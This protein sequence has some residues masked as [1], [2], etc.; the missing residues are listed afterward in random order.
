MWIFNDMQPQHFFQ[1]RSQS[2][3]NAARLFWTRLL[4]AALCLVPFL[5]ERMKAQSPIGD[6]LYTV[7]TTAVD[8][9]GR[10]W[11]YV[12]WQASSDGLVIGKKFSVNSKP[13]LPSDA[14]DYERQG[15]AVVQ[16][17]P[18]SI[19][20]LLQRGEWLGDDLAQ[21]SDRIDQLFVGLVPAGDV[22]LEEKLSIVI[23]GSLGSLDRFSNLVMLGRLHPSVNLCIGY[24]FAVRIP[25]VGPTTF[26]IRDYDLTANHDIGV[27]G[28]VTLDPAAPVILPPPGAPVQVPEFPAGSAKGDLNVKLRWSTSAPLR[29]VSL[30]NY[31]FD[32]YRMTKIYAENAGYHLNPPSANVMSQLVLAEED[33]KQVN[34]LPVLK[35]KDFNALDV[36]DFVADPTT[37]FVADDN[38]RYKEGGVAFQNGAQYYYFAAARDVLGRNGDVSKGSLVTVCDRLPPDAP[39]RLKVANDYTYDGVNQKQVLKISWEQHDDI[40]QDT[41]V[42]YYVY[43]WSSPTEVQVNGANPLV[44]QIAGPIA[45][46]P[47]ERNFYVDDG[48]GSPQ[49][50]ADYG[51]TYW[52]TVRAVDDGACDGGNY[53]AHSAPSF[54]VLRDRAGPAGPAG[55][56]WVICC[57]PFVKGLDSTDEKDPRGEQ[58]RD[59]LAYYLLT[60]ERQ[61]ERIQWADFFVFAPTP[62]NYLGRVPFLPGEKVAR[63]PWVTSREKLVGE[64]PFYSRVGSK[65]GKISSLASVSTLRSP[66]FG[67]VRVVPFEAFT[68]CR[69]VPFIRVSQD[70]NTN[71]DIPGTTTGTDLTGGVLVTD[72]KDPCRG[73][74]PNPPG[75]VGLPNDNGIEIV[76]QLTP[77]TKEFKL[78][79]RV[80]FGPLTLIGQGEADYDDVMQ[81]TYEDT[82]MPAN[83]GVVCYYGQ[84]FDEHGNASPLT[85]LS[86]CV[87]VIQPTAIPMLL[88][89]E[90]VGTEADPQMRIR[91]FCPPYGIER[92]EVS[93]GN[94]LGVVANEISDQLSSQIATSPQVKTYTINGASLENSF[95]LFH[96]PLVGP[97]FGNGAIFEVIVNVALGQEYT[98]MVAAVDKAGEVNPDSNTEIFI[99]HEEAPGVGPDVPWPARPLPSLNLFHPRVTALQLPD[100]IYPGVGISIGEFTGRDWVQRFDDI[101]TIDPNRDSQETDQQG[102]SDNLVVSI[103]HTS[104]LFSRVPN[105]SIINADGQPALDVGLVDSVYDIIRD[106]VVPPLPKEFP[107][108][109]TLRP[110]IDPNTLLYTNKVGE[111]LFPVVV[112]RTQVPNELYPEV[113]GD[114]IQVTPLM[115]EIAYDWTVDPKEGDVTEIR[116]PFLTAT[117][118]V[119]F[120]NQAVPGFIF[121]KDTQPVVEGASYIY[122]LTRFEE[123]GEIKEIV[124]TNVVIITPTP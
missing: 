13:G 104:D 34:H 53:S 101:A 75:G 9:Q 114:I 62:D 22:S 20:I 45:P 17:D 48:A 41:V 115:E 32:V 38:G 11:A 7:G 123:N 70:D 71:T 68:E 112:Y 57:E 44:N 51:K 102:Q 98:V 109:F 8:A 19:G 96:T 119:N 1:R 111:I 66:Q 86:D 87:P 65:D 124:P 16:T 31:G 47:G 94:D 43:R 23:R 46:I 28:R 91:W 21:L 5:G 33:V 64:V 15:I 24:A 2:V 30:L 6:S 69:R 79:R 25:G 100:S 103:N 118:P 116:D 78:Y 18:Q 81:I 63:L 83:S 105:L 74:Y 122:L 93:V 110:H 106:L 49:S 55:G 50:P 80:D 113:S 52:Y 88:P 95:A 56:V 35:M 27:V 117:P 108:S 14:L 36:S 97:G 73:H 12:L 120:G 72:R 92:F 39:R 10:T 4:M 121:L 54:G 61:D 26:E 58:K 107:S 42:S 67:N 29:R 77:G 90:S 59:D 3:M 82:N 37:V 84:L 99:W 89:L 76:V 85:L 40:E 60:C